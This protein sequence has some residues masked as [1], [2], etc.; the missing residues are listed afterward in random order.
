MEIIKKLMENEMKSRIKKKYKI[1]TKKEIGI[2]NNF[3]NKNKKGPKPTNTS[4][5][6]TS[7]APIQFD[8]SRQQ[9]MKFV[10]VFKGLACK[11][12]F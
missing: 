7:L 9:T 10:K 4:Q 6:L 5:S 2:A 8:L 1:D 3:K 12:I 11:I